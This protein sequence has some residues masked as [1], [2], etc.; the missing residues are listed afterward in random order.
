MVLAATHEQEIP[1]T[2]YQCR[3][4]ENYQDVST[5]VLAAVRDD[6]SFLERRKAIDKRRKE[7]E[8]KAESEHPGLRAGSR[9]DVRW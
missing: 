1:A 6:M 5:E 8:V 3:I 7:L 2:D 9:R 4:T